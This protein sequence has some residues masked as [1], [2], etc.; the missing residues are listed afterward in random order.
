[1]RAKFY[2]ERLFEF[3]AVGPRDNAL[4][5]TRS[6]CRSSQPSGSHFLTPICSASCRRTHRGGST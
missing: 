6:A 3:V 5:V 4:P 2:A 1:V